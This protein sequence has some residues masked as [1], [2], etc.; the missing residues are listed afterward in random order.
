MLSFIETRNVINKEDELLFRKLL[1]IYVE[2]LI[3]K[4]V[5]NIHT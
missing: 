4:L 2:T 1:S 5:N 3:N